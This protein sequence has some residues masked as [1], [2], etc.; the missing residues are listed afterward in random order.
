M[1]MQSDAMAKALG[2]PVVFF[3]DCLA[4][5]LQSLSWLYQCRHVLLKFI[6]DRAQTNETAMVLSME[7]IEA[8][9]LAELYGR[10]NQNG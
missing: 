4:D 2:S 1:G 3:N 6:V 7:P 5:Q 8:G 9:V 10:R